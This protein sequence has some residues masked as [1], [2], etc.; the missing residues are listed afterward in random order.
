MKIKLFLD[1]ADTKQMQSFYEGDKVQGF[2]TN[3][4]L[5]RQAGIENY[6]EYAKDISQRFSKLPISL[7][8]FADELDEMYEQAVK[9]AALGKNIYVKIPVTNTKGVSTAPII[10]KLSAQQIPLNITAVFTMEQVQQITP[11]L[12]ADVPAIISIFSGRIANAGVDPM[13]ICAETVAAVKHLPKCEVLWASSREAYNVVQAE[14]S[15]C[16]IITLTPDLLKTL[17]N[18][19]KDLTDYSLDTVKMFFNDAQTAGYQL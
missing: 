6:M 8:V 18:F 14:D 15:G 16:H 3:P 2:T 19:G 13:P 17:S 1:T 4:S 9:L 7:E 10:K 12:Q 5:M 11:A